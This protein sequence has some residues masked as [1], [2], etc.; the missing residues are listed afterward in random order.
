MIA[1]LAYPVVLFHLAVF[2]FPF[3]KFFMSGH[4]QLYLCETLGVLLPLYGLVALMIYA[5]QGRHGE[6]WRGLVE[7]AL[8]PIPV[9]G[10]G[11]RCLALARLA[12]ALEA[13][14]SAGVT[15]IEAW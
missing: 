14:L 11:R 15:I 4:W 13:L 6:T 9:L 8:A 5:A 12:A 10:A 3:A 7:R 2:L 1:D